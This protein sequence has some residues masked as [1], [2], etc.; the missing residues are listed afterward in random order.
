MADGA[1]AIT[2]SAALLAGLAGS[3]HCVA[4]CGGVAGALGMRRTSSP[5]SWR[6][7]VR[8]AGL[9]HAGRLIGYATA[10]AAFG[11]LGVALQSMLNLPMLT[12]ASRVAAGCLLVLIATRILFGWNTLA[13]VERVGARFWHSVRP[14]VGRA[15]SSRSNA[16]SLLLGLLWGWLPCGLVYSML[17]FAALSSDALDAGKP[18]PRVVPRKPDTEQ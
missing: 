2:L 12:A 3:V 1:N 6:A 11:W 8:D 13:V 16:G 7:T 15:A 5:G 18:P 17:L 4:M 9:H 10:G 14:L